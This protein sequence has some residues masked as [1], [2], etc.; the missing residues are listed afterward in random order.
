MWAI[1]VALFIIDV[2]APDHDH[3]TF[4]IKTKEGKTYLAESGKNNYLRDSVKHE[5]EK[6]KTKESG[7]D[8][9]LR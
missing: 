2:L 1:C 5:A 7:F 8:S 6:A 3:G 4:L 9:A